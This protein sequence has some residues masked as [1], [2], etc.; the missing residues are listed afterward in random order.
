MSMMMHR[1]AK[2]IRSAE[3]PPKDINKPVE[4]EQVE[5]E[6]GAEEAPAR[7]GRKPKR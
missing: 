1:A 6:N 2:R 3:Q 7:R 4:A 5:A